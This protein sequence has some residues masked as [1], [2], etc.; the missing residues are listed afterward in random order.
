M[1]MLDKWNFLANERNRSYQTCGNNSPDSD[2]VERMEKDEGEHGGNYNQR[3]IKSGFYL[4]ELFMG[5]PSDYLYN[6]FTRNRDNIWCDFYA[7]PEGKNDA[8]D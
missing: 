5:H 6:T 1:D 7:D 4:S 2:A 3:D 8:S